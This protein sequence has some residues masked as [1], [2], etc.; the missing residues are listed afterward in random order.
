MVRIPIGDRASNRPPDVP[1]N[2]VF[3]SVEGESRSSVKQHS[4]GF[5]HDP[6]VVVGTRL[7]PFRRAR[8]RAQG[9][10]VGAKVVLDNAIRWSVWKRR[11]YFGNRNHGH[12]PFRSMSSP[13]RR[14]PPVWQAPN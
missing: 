3:A 9:G 14:S 1:P 4:I 5:I 6:F 7:T 8:L 10:P 11:T 13:K 2:S 12:P